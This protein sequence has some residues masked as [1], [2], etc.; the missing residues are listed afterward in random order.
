MVKYV[1]ATGESITITPENSGMG[2][3]VKKG[4]QYFDMY[5]YDFQGRPVTVNAMSNDFDIIITSST[6]EFRK[7]YGVTVEQISDNV[8]RVYFPLEESWYIV[9]PSITAFIGGEPVSTTQNEVKIAT[10]RIG[11]RITDW[12]FSPFFMIPIAILIIIIV[13]SL[14]K[15]K[16]HAE[17]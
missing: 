13:A 14:L 15:V 12:L 6:A 8:I 7:N 17:K 16:K 9:T 5:F 1:F 11:F 3:E 4:C 2:I 10:V